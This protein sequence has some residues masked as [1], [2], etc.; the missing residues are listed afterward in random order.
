[1]SDIVSKPA[2]TAACNANEVRVVQL[3][4]VRWAHD[5]SSMLSANMA[6]SS[7][8]LLAAMDTSKVGS[9]A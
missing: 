3:L 7:V 1:M 2:S 4:R 8:N 5:V 6:S 9:S